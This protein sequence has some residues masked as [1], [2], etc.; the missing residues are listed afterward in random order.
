MAFNIWFEK[1]S[2]STGQVGRVTSI[3]DF[4]TGKFGYNESLKNTWQLII[5]PLS[6]FE[7]SE[8]TFN[9]LWI[10]RETGDR[11]CLLDDIALVGANAIANPTKQK[12]ITSIVTDNGVASATKEDDTFTMK[13]FGG[14]LVSAIG[15]A[16]SWTID[17]TDFYTKNEVDTADAQILSAAN[18]YTDGKVSNTIRNGITTIAPSENAVYDALSDKANISDLAITR[19]YELTWTGGTQ[20]FITPDFL[21]DVSNVIVSGVTLSESQYIVNAG[22]RQITITP[23]LDIDD[24]III[25]YTT[26]SDLSNTGSYTPTRSKQ[27]DTFA[28]FNI[29]KAIS[30]SY[31]RIINVLDDED[32]G[33]PTIYYIFPNGDTYWIAAN[34]EN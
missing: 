19:R 21:T 18:D 22:S 2:G 11:H 8:I 26:N 29:E 4:K 31:T 5:I 17:L 3:L 10:R 23:T 32:K 13:G 14:I 34:K 15:K 25:I 33:L 20:T 30:S 6:V 28:D 16:I 27:V 24:Y 9:S 1:Q 7:I 12:A